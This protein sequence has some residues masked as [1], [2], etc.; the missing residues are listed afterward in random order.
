M[1]VEGRRMAWADEAASS[2]LNFMAITAGVDGMDMKYIHSARLMCTHIL[3]I[4]A[5]ELVCLLE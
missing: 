3:Y 5:S 2:L 4:C 1:A